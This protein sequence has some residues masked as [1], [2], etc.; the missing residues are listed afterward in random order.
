M[1][2]H[3]GVTSE[4][5]RTGAG[6]REAAIPVQTAPPS[7]RTRAQRAGPRRVGALVLLVGLT[8]T[9]L[10]TIPAEISYRHNERRLLRLQTGLTA[11]LLQATPRQLEATLGRVVG[12]SAESQDPVGTFNNAIRP[13]MAPDGPF[14]SASLAQVLGG[15]ATVVAH[16]GTAPIADLASPAVLKVFEDAAKSPSLTTSRATGAG[17]QK[18]GYLL[19]AKGQA[20]TFVVSASQQLPLPDRVAVPKGSPDANLDFSLYFGRT[21]APG[22][23]ILSTRSPPSGIVQSTTVPFANTVLTLVAS[24]RGSLAGAWAQDLPWGIAVVGVA[25]SLWAAFEAARLIQRRAD[26]ESSARTNRA[27]YQQQ[28]AVSE[29]LQRSLLPRALPTFPGVDIAAMYVPGTHDAEVGG[30]WY[31]VVAV[32]ED[33][34]VFVVGDVSGHGV[35]AAGTMA[36]LRYTTRT[37]AKLGFTPEEILRRAND[38][39]NLMDD[40]HFATVLVGTV[41]LSAR[42][43]VVASAGHPPPYLVRGDEG[44]FVT[45]AAGTPLGIPPV[46]VPPTATVTFGPG[47]TLVA[48]T[49]GLIERRDENLDA[50][51]T[52][53]AAAASPRAPSAE[54]LAARIV[55]QLTV[56][57]H[58]DDIA[59]LVIRYDGTEGPASDDDPVASTVA[60]G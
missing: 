42:E 48:F 18:I 60:R 58:D 30:D 39:I 27:M 46:T 51:L 15:H 37:L 11:S 57:G 54:G 59:I 10:L 21:T 49:D 2:G 17:V 53:L 14:A 13:S 12:L 56:D 28:R 35:P 36:A 8:V 25:L 34:F 16:A 44:A 7:P 41:S 22:A 52:R 26:A 38:E 32:D 29:L 47:S 4:D 9:A 40:G 50:G 5:G 20:G 6:Q 3:E 55:D 33:R 31:S 23:L 45:V 24:P 19:S 43:M 1:P